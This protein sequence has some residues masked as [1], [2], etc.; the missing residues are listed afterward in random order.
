MADWT[1]IKIYIRTFKK[2]KAAMTTGFGKVSYR[3]EV[4]SGRGIDYEMEY[5]RM[6]SYAAAITVLGDA[7]ERLQPGT[8]R[9]E[10]FTDSTY[11]AYNI[12]SGNAFNWARNGFWGSNGRPLRHVEE[13][14][15]VMRLLGERCRA[16]G[17]IKCR[18][19]PEIPS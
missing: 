12:N 18:P 7:L 11:L 6:N 1:G 2:G 5:E 19:L 17:G 9:V 10:V 14:K 16:P 13:W 8:Y 15:R 4:E 3:M